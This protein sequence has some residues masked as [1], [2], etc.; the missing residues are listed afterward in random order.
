MAK[1]KTHP[2]YDPPYS[3]QR[4]RAAFDVQGNPTYPTPKPQGDPQAGRKV[5]HTGTKHRPD[6]PPS[7]PPHPPTKVTQRTKHQKADGS[8]SE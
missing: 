2:G 1:Q 4:P 5:T 6:G 7:P 8:W 3:G